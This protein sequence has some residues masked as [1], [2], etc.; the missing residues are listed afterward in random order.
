MKNSKVHYEHVKDKSV[1]KK[2]ET[3]K[4]TNE[5]VYKIKVIG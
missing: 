1:F 4:S 5:I 3:F 2:K